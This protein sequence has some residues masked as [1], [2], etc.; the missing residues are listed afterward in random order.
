MM[1]T[2]EIN[3]VIRKI[4]EDCD[5]IVNYHNGIS[6][7]CYDIEERLSGLMDLL[8]KIKESLE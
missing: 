5:R 2:K 1:K 4:K 6:E 7:Y 3:E 8:E